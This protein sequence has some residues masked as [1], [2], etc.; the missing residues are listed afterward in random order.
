M[1][2]ET[3]FTN[4]G[5]FTISKIVILEEKKKDLPFYINISLAAVDH[6]NIPVIIPKV[7]PQT[8]AEVDLHEGG[9]DRRIKRLQRRRELIHFVS[10]SSSS[11][12]T[13]A[14]VDA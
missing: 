3:K 12:S 13:A 1:T 14:S 10:S 4:D 5:F 6:E 7:V 9:H 8:Q 11:S 2:G